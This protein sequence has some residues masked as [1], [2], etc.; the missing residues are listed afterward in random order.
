M[1]LAGFEA[2]L[3][4]V[5]SMH[6]ANGDQWEL[7]LVET[8]VFGTANMCVCVRRVGQTDRCIV[9]PLDAAMRHMIANLFNVDDYAALMP[10]R[11]QSG[12]G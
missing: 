1:P 5:G 4:A 6:L 11:D 2:V 12:H 7:N 8:I 3:S 10:E 9:F